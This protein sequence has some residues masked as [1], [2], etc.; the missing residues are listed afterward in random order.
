MQLTKHH[1]LGNDFL[2]LLD[3]AGN[4]P[5]DEALARALCDRH[6]GIGADGIMRVIPAAEKN[7]RSKEDR[8]KCCLAAAKRM[9]IRQHRMFPN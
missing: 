1:G 8:R 7:R 4:Q 5:V 2:V 3:V 6:R 9:C